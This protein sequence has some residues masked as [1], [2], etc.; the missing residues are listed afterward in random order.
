M[1]IKKQRKGNT[2]YGVILRVQ[3]KILVYHNIKLYYVMI[4]L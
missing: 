3:E 4:K 2:L 1:I